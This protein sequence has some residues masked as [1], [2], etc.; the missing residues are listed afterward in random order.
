MEST[1]RVDAVTV[2]SADLIEI[3][4]EHSPTIP[5]SLSSLYAIGDRIGSGGMGDVFEARCL[6]DDSLVALK[7]ARSAIDR[8]HIANEA[9]CL[10]ALSHR[11]IV[12]M[13]DVDVREG[14]DAFLAIERIDGESL[15]QR[16]RRER[17]LSEREAIT[18]MLGLL[19]ALA[20][21]HD[22]GLVHCDVKP[23][24]I[25]IERTPSGVRP[26][27]IDFGLAIDPH[28]GS[29]IRGGT[30]TYMAPE[31]ALQTESFDRRADLYSAGTVLYCM[32]AG[33]TPFIDRTAL[34][35]L[36]TSAKNPAP[37]ISEFVSVRPRLQQIIERA[38][39]FD[40]DERFSSASE[41][42]LALLALLRPERR[43]TATTH[44]PSAQD[45]W[46]VVAAACAL[47]AFFA[48]LAKIL[49]TPASSA[50]EQTAIEARLLAPQSAS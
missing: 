17:R 22:A 40:P 8:A 36:I 32:L 31:Q 37:P 49:P 25:M 42:R 33:R 26:V 10:Q 44:Q 20:H 38:L 13:I 1:T 19:D 48:A 7:V 47:I 41:F 2:R 9:L 24:N 16:L 39:S 14:S 29:T 6:R 12:R 50:I 28:G 35:A 15:Q 11:N 45:R 23:A 5:T 18:I 30:V 46:V 21:V 4:E 34:A 27:L 3:T 43:S